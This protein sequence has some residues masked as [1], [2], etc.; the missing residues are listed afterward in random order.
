MENCPCIDGLPI[1][2]MC[3]SMAMLIIPV[4]YPM[5]VKVG[6][7]WLCSLIIGLVGWDKWVNRKFFQPNCSFLFSALRSA[8]NVLD[9]LCN[10]L[11][12]LFSDVTCIDQCLTCCSTC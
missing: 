7:I 1:K 4:H 2:K 3:F 6:Y 9:M 10:M 5:M 12:L 11:Q 8:L